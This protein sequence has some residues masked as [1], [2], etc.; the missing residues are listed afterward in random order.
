L[1]RILVICEKPRAAE[2]IAQALDERGKP[3]R[4][5][6]MRVPYYLAYRGG[7][8]LIVVPALGHLYTVAQKGGRWT[9]PI[10]DLKWVPA[11]EA[12][13]KA[14]RTRV[15]IEAV[16]RLSKEAE[17]YVSAC[18]YDLEGSLIAYNILRYACGDDSLKRARRMRFS[19][20]TK[21]DILRAWEEME[22]T[23]DF[24]LIEAGKARHE[25]DWLFGINLSRAL[26]LS[27]KRATG[28]YRTLSIG[29]V[30]GPT[31]HF[32]KER[33]VEVR[34]FVPSPY[35]VIEAEA[36]ISGKRYKVEYSISRITR[37]IEALEIER[38]CR[39][40]EGVITST[41]SRRRRQLPPTL[42]NLGDLQ[43]EAYRVL[44]YRPSR[45]LRLA[46]SLY[47]D[48]Y[49][50][51][52]RTSSQKL[53]PTIDVRE[54]LRG[55]R[56]TK[57]ESLAKE[58]LSK[59]VL[60][61][62]E[63]RMDDPAHPA[64][65]PTGVPPKGL[66][67][68][69]ARLYDLICR[70]FMASLADVAVRE[71]LRVEMD[72][73]GHRFHLRGMRIIEEAWMRFY[74][75]YVKERELEL[76]LLREGMI[77]KLVRVEAVRRFTK[78]PSRFNQSSL[79]RRMEEMEIGTKATRAEI[80]ETLYRRGY[81]EGDPM[82]ITD[83]GF[84]VVET[85]SHYCPEILSVEMTR[86]L[87]RRL[88]AIQ[89]GEVSSKAVVEEAVKTLKP[90]LE[91]FREREVAIGLEIDRAVKGDIIR[92][93][94]L[95]SCPRCGRE[96][97]IFRGRESGKRFAGCVG[98]FDGSCRMTYPLPQKGKIESTGDRCRVCG[99]P[100]IRVLRRGR[101]PWKLCID[102]NCPSKGVRT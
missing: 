9:Y 65:H 31:L 83:L 24:P 85:L 40:K 14:S 98:Y 27:V 6:L 73:D 17:A 96:L 53:P 54:I 3:L 32:L 68:A 45:T 88:E 82:R 33:E 1:S 86:R 2:R 63:G 10:F 26:T 47:L 79:L 5:R 18:D 43:R 100:V 15:F 62:R 75:P 35:W 90:I 101:R 60:R 49:I 48:A 81:V 99:A 95:G 34:T 21:R 11:Y 39:N 25:V 12:D 71:S 46:E 51:Y 97:R 93:N 38:E 28:F 80:I 87:E 56:E 30:Q 69:R 37:E 57:Y 41:S 58:L 64:I 61:P 78:P 22:E 44:K 8:E 7:D 29:R 55:L 70:R 66:R 4:K 92:A 91:R 102:P 42:F 36:E 13:R 74:K 16:T 59:K 20:L 52:P 84:A 67:G 94:T 76:P 23:L 77:L 89:L 50:S 72:V 19:A